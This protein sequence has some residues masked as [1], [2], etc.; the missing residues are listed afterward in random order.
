MTDKDSR[1]D[2]IEEKIDKL[3][4][5]MINVARAEEKLIAL[6]NKYSSHYDRMN[7]FSRKLDEQ[8]KD[9]EQLKAQ[10]QNNSK[11]NWLIITALAANIVA[12]ILM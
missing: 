11:F 8:Q 6:E 4:E 10:V 12:S 3:T 7:S 5:A 9:V 1:L 2:R